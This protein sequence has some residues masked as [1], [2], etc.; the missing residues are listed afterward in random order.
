M[1]KLKENDRVI[2]YFAGHGDV[3][4][5]IDA[6]FLLGFNCEA[7]P[8]AASDAIDI[9]MLERYVDAITKKNVKVI[10]ISDACRSGKL[11]GG[12][13]GAELTLTALS[14]RFKNTIKI[15][16]CGPGELSEETNFRGGGHGVFTYYLLQALYGM[17]D[18]DNNNVITKKEID[19]YL[20][21]K[22][23]KA[24]NDRQNPIIEGNANEVILDVIPEFKLAMI[25]K[26]QN[27]T[28]K[29]TVATR[30]FSEKKITGLSYNDSLLIKKFYTQVRDGKL[31]IPE[32]DNAYETFLSAKKSFSNTDLVNSMKY[33]LA[34]SL[35][36]DVQPLLN[37]F[38][39]G[40]FQEYPYDLFEIANKKLD[41][42]KSDLI[43]P[44]DY[45]YN[46]IK[47]LQ[48]FFSRAGYYNDISLKELLQ[49]DSILPNTA[50][51]NCEIARC[52]AKG[53]TPDTATAFKYFRKSI[54]LAPTWPF[55]H[56]VAGLLYLDLNM[57]DQA[58]SA[59]EKS[60]SIKSDFK[61][62]LIN[63]GV[64][65][66]RLKDHEKEFSYYQKALAIEKPENAVLFS[67]VALYW[68]NKEVYD[69]AL[70]YYRKGYKVDAYN[71]FNLGGLIKC[72]IKLKQKDSASFYIKKI[73]YLTPVTDDDYRDVA[74]AYLD[75]GNYDEAI[76]NYNKAIALRPSPYLYNNLGVVLEKVQKEVE[77]RKYYK[78]ALTLDPQYSISMNNLAIL[79]DK[80]K[81]FDSGL[82]YYRKQ[83]A[84]D[85]KDI[86]NISSMISNFLSQKQKDSALFY[87]KMME[88]MNT[89]DALNLRRIGDAYLDVP[90]YENAISY[91]F[92]AL[93]IKP[94]AEIYNNL[95]LA[96]DYQD[97]YDDAKKYYKLALTADRDY[98]T[99]INN[100]SALYNK[101]K[102]YDS[103][104][105]YTR[106]QFNIT[107]KD[108]YSMSAMA[109]MFL[110]LKQK[111]SALAYITMM[112]KANK[113]DIAE[114]KAIANIYLD[115][116][117]YEKALRYYFQAL[118]IMPGP[119][120]YNNIGLVYDDQNKYDDA[121]KYYLSAVKLTPDYSISISNLGRL[122]YKTN[123]YDSSAFYYQIL[124]RTEPTAINYNSLADAY[125]SMT[126]YDSAIVYYQKAIALDASH[127]NYY[128]NLGSSYY[129]L[130]KN[131]ESVPYFE[132]ALAMDSSYNTVYPK[133]AYGYMIEKKYDNAINYYNKILS[134]D[135]TGQ[136]IYH[137]NIACARSIQHKQGDALIAFDRSLKTGYLD[138]QH[139][140]ED[141]DLDNIRSTPAFKKIIETYFKKEEI[142]K[143][144]KLFSSK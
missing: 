5:D 100:L 137:Y 132:K 36:D 101:L 8:Y 46:D 73:K 77:A 50:Y 140:N 64:V 123:V 69:S 130:G 134:R 92:K 118:T 109:K 16:S 34:A 6:G 82:Y 78:M 1:D 63:L 17:C 116:P 71:I 43:M 52:Y 62:G 128:V 93:A 67:D 133:L 106:R 107:P 88:S 54:R 55:P 19:K 108:I 18:E 138:L 115:V 3:D 29:K 117:D 85:P 76:I 22:V 131:A 25:A 53:L 95:G 141:T 68:K 87:L 32:G 114:L 136:A 124:V 37:R 42:I 97:K 72:F 90:D 103:A 7:T 83:Y 139:L 94:G 10:L 33:D 99:S 21:D 39:R 86:S 57:Y 20:R 24:T 126:E 96:Y 127:S 65:Y 105:Y 58:K 66:S 110:K 27:I 121:K 81:Q 98:Q 9:S 113:N 14:S 30:S 104:L 15:L 84:F 28:D 144:P 112:E 2:I 47:A 59:L 70:Y 4:N 41:I 61:L 120:I 135:T 129:F 79:Y 74:D 89:N 48:I 56:F 38:T 49:A 102:Q 13:H 26:S 44:D 45:R 122:Y 31:N 60:L 142:E 12:A 125:Y 111:D 35:E 80:Q 75:D 11:T 91:Y 40:E 143:Y 23:G 119:D 51:I